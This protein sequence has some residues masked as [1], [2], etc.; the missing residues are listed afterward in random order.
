MKTDSLYYRLF[1]HWPQIALELLGLPYSGSDYRFLSEEIKQT[2]F[3]VDGLFKPISDNPEHP[4][5]FVEVQYQ[6]DDAFYGRLFSEIALY[7]YRQKP[8]RSWRALVIYPDRNTEKRASIEFQPFL[9][10]PQLQR[11]YLEDYQ[12]V[13]GNTPALAMMQLLA[14]QESQQTIVLAQRLVR[15]RN[16]LD[17]DALDFI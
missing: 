1:Q 15:Q 10:L 6:P 17:L 2:A 4:L 7:L 12:A 13:A 16:T 9:Q 5:I 3:R 11:I 8:R 14:C